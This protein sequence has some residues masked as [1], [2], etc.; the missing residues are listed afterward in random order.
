MLTVSNLSFQFGKTILFDSVNVSFLNGNCYGII[1]ANG[2]GKS[3]FLKILSGKLKPSSGSVLLESNK[4]VS[5]LEQDHNSHNEFTIIDTVLKGNNELYF[6]KKE[7]DSIYAKSNFSSED[8]DRVGEL[9]NRFEEMNGWSAESEASTLLS[10]IGISESLHTNLISSL[11]GI[12][13]VKVLIAQCIFGNPDVLIMDEPTNDLDYDTINWLVS[14]LQ[15]FENTVIVVS[16][17]RHFLDSVCTHISDIDFGKITNFTGN[18]SFWQQSSQLLLNQKKIANK[19]SE[20][21]IKELKEFIA[22]FSANVSKSKQAT[23]RKKMLDKIII[24]EIKPSSRKYPGIIFENERTLGDQILNV[25]NLSYIFEGVSYLS[26]VNFNVNKGDKIALISKKSKVCEFFFDI[27]SEKI[28]STDGGF[29]WGVTTKYEYLPVHNNH[30]FNTNDNILDWLSKFLNNK[31]E[32]DELYLRSFFGKM[33]FNG[34]DVYKKVN[35][36]SGGEKVRCLLSKIMMAKP[37]VL[38]L[39]EPTNHLD[40]ESITAFNNALKIFKGNIILSSQDFEFLNTL[41]NRVIEITPN[42]IIDRLS[43]YEEYLND[44]EIKILRQKLYEN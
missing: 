7:M 10:N 33:L 1:G 11:S 5:V 3:T 40:L 29:K 21:R 2:S 34:D 16:H 41:V 18:Y 14:F 8:A 43:T 27:I 42:G 13:K 15:T 17:D 35:V 26:K 6:V 23:S 30:Y 20:E 19:K 31:E 9:Q 37:N 38:L 22:R 36:L 44:K 4:R 32:N 24:N 39:N 12:E 25:E 28:N